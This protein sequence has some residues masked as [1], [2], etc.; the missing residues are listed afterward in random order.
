LQRRE[1]RRRFQLLKRWSE[2]I[3]PQIILAVSLPHSSH[4]TI[5]ET[6]ILNATV[7]SR[8]STFFIVL[9]VFYKNPFVQN[10][11][12]VTGMAYETTVQYLSLTSYSEPEGLV[13]AF[14]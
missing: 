8:E 7:L 2:W 5:R 10:R 6:H 3:S 1:D 11:Q 9:R 13:T 4:N 14:L 12:I